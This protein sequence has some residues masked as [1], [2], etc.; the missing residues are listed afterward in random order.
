PRQVT[1]FGGSGDDRIDSVAF[2]TAGA[3]RVGG[4][5]TSADLPLR[6]AAQS[7]YGAKSDGFYA[8]IG[9]DFL[10]GPNEILL[11]KDAARALLLR[12]G[13]NAVSPPITFRTSDPL[14]LRFS[15]SGRPVSELTLPAGTGVV[16]EA[17]ADSGEVEITASSAGFATKTIRVKLYPAVLVLRGSS[18]AST[19]SP[20][21]GAS[22]T[23]RA[24]DP[25]TGEFTGDTFYEP[26]Q[27]VLPTIQW[28]SSHPSVLEILG[29]SEFDRLSLDLLIRGPGQSRISAVVPGWRVIETESALITVFRPEIV[30][31]SAPIRLGQ[32][33]QNTLP[34]QFAAN[35]VQPISGTIR[36]TLTARSEDPSR[37]LLSASQGVRG[38]GQLSVAFD[39][40][41]PVIY[42]QALGSSGEVR[43]ILTSPDFAGDLSIPVTL[44]PSVLRWGSRAVVNGTFQFVPELKLTVGISGFNLATALEGESGGFNAGQVPGTPPVVLKFSNSDPSVLALSRLTADLTNRRIETRALSPGTSQLSLSISTDI[45]RLEYSSIAVIVTPAPAPGISADARSLVIGKDLQTGLSIRGA[46]SGAPI[47]LSSSDPAAVL[48]SPTSQAPGTPALIVNAA[49]GGGASVIVQSLKDQGET[50]VRIRVSGQPDIDV[51]VTHV[52]SGI[53]FSASVTTAGAIADLNVATAP[54]DEVTAT[55]LLPQSVRPGVTAEVRLRT[56]GSPITLST[57]AVTLTNSSSSARITFTPLPAGAETV[58]TAEAAGFTPS[59]RR[60]IR[61]RGA[62]VSLAINNL[63]AYLSRDTV[64][65]L[66]FSSTLEVTATSSDPTKFLIATSANA[67]PSASVRIPPASRSFLFL[68][69]FAESGTATLRIEH[70]G[71]PVREVPLAFVPL[72]LTFDRQ[73]MPVGQTRELLTRFSSSLRPGVGPFRFALRSNNPSIATVFPESIEWNASAGIPPIRVTAVAPGRATITA[74]GPETV[75]FTPLEIDVPSP[76]AASAPSEFQLGRNTQVAYSHSYRDSF[77]NGGIVSVTSSDP[78][79]LLLS[80]TASSLGSASTSVSVQPGDSRTQPVY[81]QAHGPEGDVTVSFQNADGT[82]QTMIVHIVKS[83]IGCD[84]NRSS[85]I[86]VTAGSSARV[87]CRL[88]SVAANLFAEGLQLLPG[89]GSIPL[90]LRSS[91]SAVFTVTPEGASFTPGQELFEVRGLAP[92]TA[93]L[94][95][96]Q[97]DGFGPAPDAPTV[98][99]TLPQLTSGCQEMTLGLDTQRT[100]D[101]S[102]PSGVTVTA[103]SS[104][105]ALTLVTSNPAEPGAAQT[106]LTSRRV[107][108]QQLARYGTAE[109]TLRAAGYADLI[110]PV[111]AGET[112]LRLNQ[113][114]S[115]TPLTNLSLR[116]GATT[117]V[118]LLLSGPARAGSRIFAAINASPTG[119]IAIDPAS[120]VFSADQ[121][122]ATL[123]I[124]ALAAGS[125][126]ISLTAPGSI[127]VPATPA[128]ISVTP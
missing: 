36:G 98:T 60:S 74:E 44:E 114:S 34:I 32:Y 105:P 16:L 122:E 92:G 123:N 18:N 111:V 85:H 89:A 12:P 113:L 62:D 77:P 59:T 71:R 70:A 115:T 106:Q 116:V 128:V 118:T 19:W 15:F 1:Y 119:I 86:V 47:S 82:V 117:P 61:V 99:V 22:L 45:F 24:I 14:R 38:S 103:E 91:D 95:I 112:R 75:Y 110:I 126:V 51:P 121:T 33:L 8:D 124:R 56:E 4:A 93:T 87:A 125:A 9:T 78:A 66:D 37:L 84:S 76:S 58:I 20:R 7:G 30:P 21:A 2:L 5:T 46:P 73:R 127:A 67:V 49:E 57:S 25:A 96:D 50:T 40:R 72:V 81:F 104:H 17:L 94:L 10:S 102:V 13:R 11:P 55:P 39:Q 48:F 64:G 68:H 53:L 97:P 100:C 83:W 69:A 23:L 28:T 3:T 6:N 31:P 80:R 27:G 63:P 29:P 109:I 35:G 90:R 107:T 65:T 42:A 54:L 120:V 79:R 52:S 108:I 26:R 101:I 43:V 41:P 88:E